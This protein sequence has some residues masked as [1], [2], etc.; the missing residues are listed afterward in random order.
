VLPS[1]LTDVALLAD[2]SV[3]ENTQSIRVAG[4]SRIP[5][6]PGSIRRIQLDPSDPPAHPEAIRAVLAADLIA[7]GPGSHTPAFCR[8]CWCRTCKRFATCAIRVFICNVATQTGETDG[9]TACDTGRA[10]GS[11]GAGL[12]D[13]VLANDRT[14]ELPRAL[15]GSARMKATGM[16]PVHRCDLA[17]A[18]LASTPPSW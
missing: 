5:M 6:A 12:I 13:A 17:L 14:E 7:L 1:T 10:R 8:T 4:E 9:M 11:Y 16:V 15:P 3:A 2:K 18:S